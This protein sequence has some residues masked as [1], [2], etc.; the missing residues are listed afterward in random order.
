MN[1]NQ[2]QTFQ[3]FVSSQ[4]SNPQPKAKNMEQGTAPSCSDTHRIGYQ[5]KAGR[6]G[7]S[8]GA[9]APISINPLLE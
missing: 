9:S 1:P 2:G 4:D 5:S 6:K 7:G 8:F 3:I